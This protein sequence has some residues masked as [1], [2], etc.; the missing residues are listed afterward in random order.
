MQLMLDPLQ[1]WPPVLLHGDPV[2][3]HLV[4]HMAA[5]TAEVS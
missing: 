2:T 4:G 1:S 5:L 3:T